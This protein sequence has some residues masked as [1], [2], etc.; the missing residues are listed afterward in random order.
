MERSNIV[1]SPYLS[2]G[3]MLDKFYV[4]EIIF[5]LLIAHFSTTA[6]VSCQIASRRLKPGCDRNLR[7]L[8]TSIIEKLLTACE[9]LGRWCGCCLSSSVIKHLIQSI[10]YVLW[11][12][13]VP[14]IIFVQ[15]FILNISNNFDYINYLRY[16]LIICPSISAASC[17]GRGCPQGHLFDLPS[18][19]SKFCIHEAKPNALLIRILTVK[20]EKRYRTLAIYRPK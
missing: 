15:L 17:C 13:E 3:H 11:I 4:E 12:P 14:V 7:R 9:L 8:P 19:N 20:P 2:L 1:L 6:T 5:E 16:R 18:M 10:N